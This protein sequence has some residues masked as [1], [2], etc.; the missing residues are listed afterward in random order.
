MSDIAAET[1][2]KAVRETY[3]RA[4]AK[5]AGCCGPSAAES[6]DPG[7]GCGSP[8]VTTSGRLG[9]SDAERQSVP[10]GAD[11]GLGCGNPQAIA[12]LRPGETVVDL[13]SGGGFDCFLASKQVGETGRA[14]GVDMTPEMVSKARENA[15][16]GGY[17]NVSFRLG[18][19]EHLPVPDE[20]ADAVISNCV[21]NLSPDKPQV[22]RDAFRVLKPGGRLAIADIAVTAE[23]PEELRKDLALIAGCVAGAVTVE[24]MRRIVEAAGF[25]GVRI[26][27]KDGRREIVSQWN[28]GR[29]PEEYVVSVNVEASKPQ[30]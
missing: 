22:Y 8:G 27:P 10:D 29:K 18:E 17:R 4:A 23:L 5:V 26:A 16:Q 11:L 2:R 12:Q 6:E 24:E 30:A 7:C 1:V 14:I 25:R 21:I 15:E 20:S 28:P 3:G 13:G 9:Y 19:I